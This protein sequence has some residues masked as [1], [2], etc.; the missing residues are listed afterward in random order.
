MGHGV[1]FASLASNDNSTWYSKHALMAVAYELVFVHC[2]MA[3]VASSVVVTRRRRN[4][5][6]CYTEVQYTSFG[7][8]E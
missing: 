5:S 3:T 1:G 6:N 8:L 7:G 4:E 2:G